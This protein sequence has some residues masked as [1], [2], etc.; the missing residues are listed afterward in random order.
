MIQLGIRVGM[1]SDYFFGDYPKFIWCVCEDGEVYEAK[2][3]ATSP[4]RYHG[5]RLEEEDELRNYIKSVWK[6][7][8]PQTGQ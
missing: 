3:D 8:W 2:T 6:Q 7:R 5:Y 4:G 1:I